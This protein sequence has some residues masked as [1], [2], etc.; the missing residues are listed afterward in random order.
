M[1]GYD[2]VI[3][4]LNN[5]TS[6][7]NMFR[8]S[9]PLFHRLHNVL[10]SSYG[11][12]LTDNMSSVEALAMFLWI[13][14]P[15]Q[16]IRQVDDRFERSTK[17]ISRKFHEVLDCVY[18]LSSDI[19]KLKDPQ[20]RTVHSRLQASKFLLYFNNCIGAIDGTHMPVVVPANKVGQYVGRHGYSSQNVLAIC[21]FD[22]RFTFAVAGWLGSV[23]DTR[24][25]ND[26]I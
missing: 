10:V 4:T 25:F 11:L 19:I 22:M 26:A 14:G 13:V 3:K 8:M 9:R 20:F 6:C 2:W 1:S 24:V 23:H 18:I 16:P 21:D 12:K 17:T 5:P 15:T 7:F